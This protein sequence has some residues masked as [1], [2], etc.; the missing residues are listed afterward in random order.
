MGLLVA[1]L[2]GNEY[3]YMNQVGLTGVEALDNEDMLPISYDKDN[4]N[5]AEM[6]D[7]C[8]ASLTDTDIL[9]NGC[10]KLSNIYSQVK[11]FDLLFFNREAKLISSTEKF[12]ETVEAIKSQSDKLE[13]VLIQS[14]SSLTNDMPE[15]FKL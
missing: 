1:G 5:L 12:Y 2:M 7:E 6:E 13:K 14:H 4:D 8:P 9:A 10:A 3:K 15:D 11:S